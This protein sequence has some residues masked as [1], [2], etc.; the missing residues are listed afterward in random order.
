MEDSPWWFCNRS[1]SSSFS[2]SDSGVSETLEVPE[3]IPFHR[4]LKQL[5]F[6]ISGG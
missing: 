1:G 6:L 5:F 3:K 4:K 2:S